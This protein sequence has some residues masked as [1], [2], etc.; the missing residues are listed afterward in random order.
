[1]S[2]HIHFPKQKVGLSM[3]L[4]DYL[5]PEVAVAAVVTAAVFSPRARKFLRRGAVYGM[6]GILKAG[7]LATGFAGS[8]RQGAQEIQSTA[9]SP[10][11][12]EKV[13]ASN[14]EAAVVSA[15]PK[16]TPTKPDTA[17]G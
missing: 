16:K 12:G 15:G 11:K 17:K 2:E 13:V 7:D 9:K 6:A 4:E 14:P 3:A 1:M 10:A 8:I 5:E